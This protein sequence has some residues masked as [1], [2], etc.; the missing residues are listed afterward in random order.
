[1]AL[2][3]RNCRVVSPVPADGAPALRPLRGEAMDALKVVERAD[4][5]IEGSSIVSVRVLR[6]LKQAPVRDAQE[7]RAFRASIGL[8]LGAGGAARE[9]AREGATGAKPVEIDAAGRVL[10]PAFV[11][12]HTHACWAGER[13]DEWEMKRTGVPYLKILERGGG[14]M[15]SVRAV[16][17]ASQDD[18]AATLRERAERMLRLGSTTIEVKSGYGLTTEDELKML[19]AVRAAARDFPGTL[20]PTAM[21]GHAIDPDQPGFV[22]RVVRE[23]LPAVAAEFPGICIDAFCEEGAWSVE[24]CLLLFT[25]ARELGLPFRVHADQ[26]NSLGMVPAALRLGARSV[27]HLEASSPEDLRALAASEAQGVVL[28]ACGFHMDNRYAKGRAFVGAG[29]ALTIA[30]NLNPGS[31]PCGSMAF[32][33][34][35]AVR[36]LGLS[37]SEALVASTFNPSRLLGLTDRGQVATGQRADLLLLDGPDERAVAFEFGDSPIAAVIAGG[38]VVT[39]A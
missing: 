4:L 12:A 8:A 13:L 19:R 36:R 37:V 31:A 33:V 27:D 24:Q 22:G 3:I 20:V 32:V 2:V 14:I 21:L 16:R 35:L 11:D 17:A 39:P 30:T 26:F 38:R 29:G 23:T 25:R 34:A 15:A 18:L 1:M 28:P 5:T 7:R 6:P 9:G 10:M